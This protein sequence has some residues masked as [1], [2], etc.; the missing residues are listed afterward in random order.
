MANIAKI[1][2][3]VIKGAK[4][5]TAGVKR[6]RKL[7]DPW[8]SPGDKGSGMSNKATAKKRAMLQKQRDKHWYTSGQTVKGRGVLQKKRAE[9][10]IKNK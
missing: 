6:N 7:T 9:T 10:K 8:S 3:K 2:T 4:P 5:E 1:V